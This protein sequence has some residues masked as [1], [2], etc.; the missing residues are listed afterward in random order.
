MKGS[1]AGFE[2]RLRY[3]IQFYN[4]VLLKMNAVEIEDPP[5]DCPEYMKGF[6]ATF[7]YDPDGVK[8]EVTYTP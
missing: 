5:V 4:A 7:F 2:S 6:Y 8:L 1:R 3:K